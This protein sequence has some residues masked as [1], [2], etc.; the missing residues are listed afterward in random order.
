MAI[1]VLKHVQVTRDATYMAAQLK[2]ILTAAAIALPAS[3][4]Q[5]DPKVDQ[6][7]IDP[8][9]DT[10]QVI[11]TKGGQ[12]YTVAAAIADFFKCG[13]GC[14]VWQGVIWLFVVPDAEL[15]AVQAILASI[16]AIA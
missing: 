9:V 1:V 8:S 16:K 12:P 7:F 6:L 15:A 2:T 14:N 13:N 10:A 4:Y 5:A 3:S 11:G